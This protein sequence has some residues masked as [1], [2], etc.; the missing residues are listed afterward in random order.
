MQV[1]MAA[2]DASIDECMSKLAATE[3]KRQK[4]LNEV[5]DF[6]FRR[7]SEQSQDSH[8]SGVSHQSRASGYSHSSQYSQS[9]YSSQRSQR[10]GSQ[11]SHQSL[12]SQLSA[13]SLRDTGL[14]KAA[15]EEQNRPRIEKQNPPGADDDP[16]IIQNHAQPSD[17]RRR[18][19]GRIERD[20]SPKTVY[21]DEARLST[22]LD[23]SDI[24]GLPRDSRQPIPSRTTLSLTNIMDFLDEDED[25]ETDE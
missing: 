12:S 16:L 13:R 24:Q 19:E 18:R 10:S 22:F 21:Q 5:L 4:L 25:T 8:Q 6:P 1:D 23:D 15:A 3:R 7:A 9:S 20:E 17:R 14:A 11:R 2:V